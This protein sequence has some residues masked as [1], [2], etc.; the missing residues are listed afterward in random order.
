VLNEPDLTK[1]RESQGKT[2][3]YEYVA[4]AGDLIFTAEIINILN[5]YRDSVV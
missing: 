4:R 1:Q 2:I 3:G 5:G